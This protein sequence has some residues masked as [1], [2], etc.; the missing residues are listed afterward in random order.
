ME[1]LDSLMDDQVVTIWVRVG[2]SKKRSLKVG[3]IYRECHQLGM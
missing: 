3:G 2:Q 1:K